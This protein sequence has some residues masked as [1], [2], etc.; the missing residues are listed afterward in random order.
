RAVEQLDVVEVGGAGDAVDLG[1]Q[2]LRFG[3][4]RAAVGGGVGGVARL[5]GQL[6]DALQVVADLGHRAFGGLRQRDA[7]VGVAGSLVHAADLGGEALRNGEA[8]GVVLGAV[9]AHAGG[10]ALQAGGEVGTGRGQVA[11]RIE[12]HHVGVDDRRHLE[13]SWKV[14]S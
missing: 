5:H 13:F 6:T 2:L 10:Q 8:G 9:D 1:Q 7:V 14:G 11:L 4:Q 12:R 3:V